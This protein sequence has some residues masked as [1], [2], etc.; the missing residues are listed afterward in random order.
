[1]G[2]G[3]NQCQLPSCTWIWQPDIKKRKAGEGGRDG[4]RVRDFTLKNLVWTCFTIS[5]LYTH[6]HICKNYR[7]CFLSPILML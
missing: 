2:A 7:F 4:E 5:L 1:M 3:I 6:V